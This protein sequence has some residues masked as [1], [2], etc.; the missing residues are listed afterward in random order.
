MAR[1]ITLVAL[2]LL[3][4]SIVAAYCGLDWAW[5]VAVPSFGVLP[6]SGVA[7]VMS[8]PGRR[9]PALASQPPV[10]GLLAAGG[11]RDYPLA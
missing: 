11:L 8:E 3:V 10:E 4:A 2:P 1:L 5:M 6:L 9:G 7:W